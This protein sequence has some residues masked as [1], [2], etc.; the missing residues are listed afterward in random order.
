LPP[1]VEEALAELA[2]LSDQRPNLAEL[3]LQLNACLRV[4]YA[5]P[6]DVEH[7][8]IPFDSARA[9]LSAGTPLLRDE[10]L[11]LDREL[12]TR[13]Q[14][15]VAAMKPYRPDASSAL[16][17]ATAAR[18]LHVSEWASLVLARNVHEVH[19]RAET[20][21]LDVPLTASLLWLT[22]FPVLVAMRA[23]LESVLAAAPWEQGYCPVCGSFPR[24]GEFRGLEQ[25]RWLRCG[26]CAAQWELSRLLCPY[27]GNRDHRQLGYLHVEGEEGKFRAATCDACGCYTKLVSTLTRLRPLQLLIMDLATMH[28]DLLAADRGFRPPA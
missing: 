27:C 10:T 2:R 9:R 19:Q 26:L 4:A 18:K 23:N 3:A 28:L 25:I 11:N 5:T 20:L 6:I 15:I 13:W 22:L 16:V 24:L 14:R 21:G 12:E 17:A 7:P 1:D 8:P